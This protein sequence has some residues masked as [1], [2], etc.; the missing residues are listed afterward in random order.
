[1]PVSLLDIA[2]SVVGAGQAVGALQGLSQS[3]LQAYASNEMLV[4]SLDALVA[5]QIAVSNDTTL[6]EAQKQSL[7]LTKELVDWTQRLGVQSPYSQEGIASAFKMAMAFGMS[8]DQ[9]K[10]ATEAVVDFAAASGQ[11]PYEMEGIILAMGQAFSRGKLQGEEAMQMLERGVPVWEYLGRSLGK[12]TAEIQDMSSRGMIPAVQAFEALTQGMKQDFGGAAAEAGTT[13]QGLT[14][15]FQDLITIAQR[16][17]ATPGIETLR[18]VAIDINDY[19]SSDDLQI[20]L[21]RIGL[22]I[23]KGVDQGIPMVQNLASEVESRLIPAFYAA[24]A[25][26]LTINAPHIWG[27]VIA[28]VRGVATGVQAVLSP[29]GVLSASLAMITYAWQRYN[30]EMD[31]AAMEVLN[32]RQWYTQSAQRLDESTDVLVRTELLH[33]DLG[34]QIRTTQR[35]IKDY[36]VQLA[37]ANLTDK[38]RNTI[39]ESRAS[40]VKHNIQL[41]ERFNQIAHLEGQASSHTTRGEELQTEIDILTTSLD[42]LYN[43]ANNPD[44]FNALVGPFLPG[45]RFLHPEREIESTKQ[46][47]K[48]LRKQ[49][50]AESNLAQEYADK[51]RSL[52]EEPLPQI[53]APKPEPPAAF[54][55]AQQKVADLATQQAEKLLGIREATSQKME[56]QWDAYYEAEA[57]AQHQRNLSA[58]ESA[59][60]HNRAIEEARY[61]FY[62]SQAEAQ[63]QWNYEQEEA[64]RKHDI[65]MLEAERKRLLELDDLAQK[66]RPATQT[67]LD[68]LA[69]T[70]ADFQRAATKRLE[71]WNKKRQLLARQGAIC[72]L[73][74][75]REAFEEQEQQAAEAYQKQEQQQRAALGRQLIDFTVAMALR[76]NVSAAAMEQMVAGIAQATGA[77]DHVTADLLG[78]VFAGITSWSLSGGQST[79]AV[80]A[81]LRALPDAAREAKAAEEELSRTLR[82]RAVEQFQRTGD[83]RAYQAALNA[84]PTQVATR[85]GL[86]T[87]EALSGS[88]VY[89]NQEQWLRQQEEANRAYQHQQ[90][91]ANRAHQHQVEEDQRTHELDL[92]EMERQHRMS[93]AEEE[94]QYQLDREEAWRKHLEVLEKMHGKEHQKQLEEAM[95]QGDRLM[96]EALAQV[97]NLDA[98]QRTLLTGDYRA[99][100]DYELKMQNWLTYQLGQIDYGD[101]KI[102]QQARESIYQSYAGLR[103]RY[104]QEH[105]GS[106]HGNYQVT[107]EMRESRAPHYYEGAPLN[108]TVNLEADGLVLHTVRRTMRVVNGQMEELEVNGRQ[109]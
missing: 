62:R 19:L 11:G 16:R 81:N 83:V 61:Q 33:R 58:E 107:P 82:E 88:S 18:P 20:Q 103:E 85:L 89:Q 32:S 91:E 34:Y 97:G 93:L 76:N 96:A 38:Q 3:A 77:Y 104:Q 4:K 45:E 99:A 42:D 65:E 64:A 49:L 84:I 52:R 56:E 23:A 26:I 37:D 100:M 28:G 105:F 55:E 50:E 71:E 43:Q 17:I 98:A 75:E 72:K 86:S 21:D 74:E 92:E 67:A 94:R 7:S 35:Q 59:Y 70:E 2:I 60:Q 53:N 15:S 27:G 13:I 9:A 30:R 51:L 41:Q 78:S 68:E 46:R 5:K 90:E 10:Q 48:K 29:L 39:L 73:P 87:D 54:T 12:T 24:G 36:D 31:K 80:L 63:R 57:E 109:R 8:I 106:F 14:S 25:A 44:W 6:I 1:M 47:I 66:Q 108:L 69:A 101:P 40:L 79:A 95:R 102:S 22:M